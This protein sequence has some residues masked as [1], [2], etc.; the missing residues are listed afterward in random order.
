MLEQLIAR[1]KMGNST[2]ATQKIF[3][4]TRTTV[5][6]AIDEAA[7]KHHGY[8]FG[9]TT[10]NGLKSAISDIKPGADVVSVSKVCQVLRSFETGKLSMNAN[11]AIDDIVSA[12]NSQR[13]E[14]KGLEHYE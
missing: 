10:A 8:A 14:M 3:V 5:L 7:S 9:N 1:V 12:V 6:A 2:I 4:V 11:K 13:T